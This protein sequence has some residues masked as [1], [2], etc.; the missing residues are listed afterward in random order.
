MILN[1]NKT[2]HAVH[3]YDAVPCYL[4]KIAEQCSR[5]LKDQKDQ[6]IPKDSERFRTIPKD[7]ERIRKV[8]RDSARFRKIRKHSERFRN[9]PNDSERDS[10][11][12]RRIRSKA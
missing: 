4:N 11:G 3:S 8:P 9:I 10:E 12:F 6:K 7:S 1:P 5:R 2:E